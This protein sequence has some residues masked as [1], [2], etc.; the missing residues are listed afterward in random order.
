MEQKQN[1]N[2][3][4]KQ[5]RIDSKM[6]NEEYIKDIHAFFDK[7]ENPS[8]DE[9]MDVSEA[10]DYVEAGLNYRYVNLADMYYLNDTVFSGSFIFNSTAGKMNTVDIKRL[11][12][13]LK[14][15]WSM[16]YNSLN[17]ENKRPILF[18]IT[19]IEENTIKYDFV[20]AWEKLD[21]DLY[22]KYVPT[23][24]IPYNVAANIIKNWIRADAICPYQLNTTWYRAVPISVNEKLF[25]G[26]NILNPNDPTPNDGLID[27]M[28]FYTEMAASYPNY[29][30]TLAPYEMTHYH[31]GTN[32]IISNFMQTHPNEEVVYR[33]VTY[34]FS[35]SPS[36]P[37]PHIA[38]HNT[39]IKYSEFKYTYEISYTL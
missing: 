28:Q 35:G 23:T 30:V 14:D 17:F 33:N 31:W 32:T 26:G 7:I 36:W 18:D 25:I 29:H 27:F 37:T 20:I 5:A 13:V 3:S 34:G 6:S 19:D 11:Y 9:F 16:K 38:R 24:Y 15:D 12:D 2:T 1:T 22:R 39:T 21:V 4:I 8:E 10:I